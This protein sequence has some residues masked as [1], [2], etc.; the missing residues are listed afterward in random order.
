[1]RRREYYSAVW[2]ALTIMADFDAKICRGPEGEYQAFTCCPLGW[3]CVTPFVDPDHYGVED[4]D[5]FESAEDF[6]EHCMEAYE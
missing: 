6:V 5:Y 1:M 3:E 4:T 2:D